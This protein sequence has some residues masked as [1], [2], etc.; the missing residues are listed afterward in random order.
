VPRSASARPTRIHRPPPTMS[1]L[2][3]TRSTLCDRRS[4]HTQPKP[5]SCM[6]RIVA[7]LVAVV[8]VLAAVAV[9]LVPRS[10]HAFCG[11]YVSG[12]RREALQQ[13]DASRADAARAPHGA[14]DAEQLPRAAAEF[15]D[16]GA[17]AVV[18]QKENVKTLP[19]DIFESHRSAR[20]AAA[21]SNTGSRTHVTC[22][23][24]C[25]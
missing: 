4:P 15:R 9:M 18:L 12:R 20:G 23:R 2:H 5:R 8:T 17:G 16:G 1:R 3:V 25:R 24:R 21:S 6:R 14:L 11:F 19:H 10:A 13:R 7:I 22:R